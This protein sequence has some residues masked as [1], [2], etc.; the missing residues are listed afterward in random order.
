M[1]SN[2]KLSLGVFLLI[3]SMTFPFLFL[4]AGCAK[5]EPFEEQPRE[6]APRKADSTLVLGYE[7]DSLLY[8]PLYVARQKNFFAGEK[9]HLEIQKY[10]S[11]QEAVEGV[12][13]G[14]YDLILLG[15]ELGFFLHQQEQAGKLVYL[16]PCT[17]QNG[18]ALLS[19]P[20]KGDGNKAP[21]QNETSAQNEVPEQHNTKAQNEMPAQNGTPG[22]NR[23]AEQQRE[24]FNWAATKGK[25]ILGTRI[26]DFS[27]IVLEKT[28]REQ[29]LRPLVD[30]HIINN[31]PPAL[32]VGTYQSGTAQFFLATEPATSFLEQ[33]GMGEMAVSLHEY[34]G[35]MLTSVISVAK[36]KIPLEGEKY[37]RFL[38][39]YARALDWIEQSGPDELAMTVKACFPELKEKALIRGIARYKNLGCW[40]QEAV[41]EEKMLQKLHAF[42]LE[43]KE[44]KAPLAPRAVKELSAPPLVPPAEKD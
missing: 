42:L 1:A 25:V 4:G 31:L 41:I 15:A 6:E 44:L 13:S 9:L 3:V 24:A 37:Q 16:A 22:Q 19:R 12:L 36:E 40:P 5:P 38:N 33:E 10:A 2:N 21:G 14:K 26:G 27:Q 43:A 34:T 32:R 7:E 35:P 30:V 18:W 29:G 11:T 39:A 20:Q 17:I 28:L 8:L 23:P